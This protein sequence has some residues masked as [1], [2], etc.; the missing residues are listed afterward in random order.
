MKHQSPEV[1]THERGSHERYPEI[2]RFLGFLKGEK[3]VSSHTLTAY[4]H[5]LD[6]FS[7]FIADHLGIANMREF[8]PERVAVVDIRLYMGELLKN[9]MQ[10]KSIARKLASLKSFYR[11]LQHTGVIK[12]SVLAY[13]TTPKYPRNVPGFL[14]EQQTEKLFGEVIPPDLSPAAGVKA[15]AASFELERDRCLLEVLYGCGLRVSEVAGL[16]MHHV[17]L[18]GG[19]L[20]ITGKGSKQRIVPLGSCAR[21]A[22]KKY[23]E[24][25]R[26]FFRI[27]MKG[28]Y[29]DLT[30]VFVTKKGKKIYPML[31]QRIT[32]KYLTPVTEQKE[33][34]P[35]I[36]RHTF[37]THMLNSGADLKS[38][39]E[40][41]GHSSL[42]TTE[43][44]THVTFNR[45]REVYRK[46]HPKA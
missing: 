40:M 8:S 21:E 2:E 9:G 28:D 38:V 22:L 24:V 27:I 1:R 16:E 15:L 44:Y 33:R 17:S 46:A 34:N 31:V 20:K 25:R 10:P 30:Y 4:R 12:S 7:R 39:S 18:E 23:F 41:L 13:V 43:I 45:L 42:S 26:N 37:A 5:D 3:N 36:L 6:Q 19:S 32:R 35:H 14:T 29:G 11:Y